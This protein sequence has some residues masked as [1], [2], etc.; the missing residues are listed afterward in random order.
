M[1]CKRIIDDIANTPPAIPVRREAGTLAQLFGKWLEEAAV[2]KKAAT[3]EV[4]KDR[5]FP[6]YLGDIEITD[7]MLRGLKSTNQ[8]R[9]SIGKVPRGTYHV[10]AEFDS[11]G[12]GSFI[13][14]RLEPKR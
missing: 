9:N 2:E 12:D 4:T 3:L 5:G 11:A 6:E 8:S 13:R 1:R 14:L 7:Q 10:N